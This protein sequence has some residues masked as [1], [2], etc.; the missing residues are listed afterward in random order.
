MHWSH[1]TIQRNDQFPWQKLSNAVVILAPASR[2]AH[3]LNATA[4]WFWDFL[5]L[6]K[7]YEQTLQAFLAEYE[8]DEV[9]AAEDLN[10][11]LD[12]LSGQNLIRTL[13]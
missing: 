9:R 5:A 11:F 10:V 8:V 7:T 12:K 13:S 1:K 4:S 2:K 6:P 3:E